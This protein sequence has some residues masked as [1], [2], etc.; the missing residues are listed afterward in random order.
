MR[1][2][3]KRRVRKGVNSRLSD[4]QSIIMNGVV[5]EKQAFGA[6]GSESGEAIPIF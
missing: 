5:A 2:V 1:R 3:E 4:H 6:A